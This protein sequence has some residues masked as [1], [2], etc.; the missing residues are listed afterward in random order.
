MLMINIHYQVI[1]DLII[2]SVIIIPSDI[3][4]V[5]PNLKTVRHGKNTKKQMSKKE[6]RKREILE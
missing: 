6:Y 2:K 5:Y 1:Y 4:K 3:K